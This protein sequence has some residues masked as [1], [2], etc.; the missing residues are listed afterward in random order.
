MKN[1]EFQKIV[2]EKFDAMEKRF[3]IQG[4]QIEENTDLLASLK[5]N[6]LAIETVTASNWMDIIRLKAVE[7]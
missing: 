5:K 6:L 3:D 2:L 7:K 4:S 1:E